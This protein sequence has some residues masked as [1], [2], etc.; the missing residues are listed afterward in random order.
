MYHAVGPNTVAQTPLFISITVRRQTNTE[1]YADK[2]AK[3]LLKFF[4]ILERASSINISVNGQ[5]FIG[6]L[7]QALVSNFQAKKRS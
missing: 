5:G 6:S 2:S 4:V 1:N 3:E 7:R